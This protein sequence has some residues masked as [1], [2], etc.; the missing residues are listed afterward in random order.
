MS[1][2]WG[3]GELGQRLKGLGKQTYPVQTQQQLQ[4]W[5]MQA[6]SATQIVPKNIMVVILEVLARHE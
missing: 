3:A 4:K 6:F 5:L 1:N 2:T